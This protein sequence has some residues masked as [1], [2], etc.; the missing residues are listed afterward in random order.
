VDINNNG[1]SNGLTAPNPAAQSAVVRRTWQASALEPSAVQYAEAHGT[2]TPLGDPI[3]AQ[4]LGAVF[5]PERAG[6]DRLRIGSLKSNIG[7]AEG[8]AGIAGLI[9]VA[10]ALDHG[11]IPRSLHADEPNPL[12]FCALFVVFSAFLTIAFPEARGCGAADSLA[13]AVSSTTAVP[14]RIPNGRAGPGSPVR[15]KT[16]RAS[17][18]PRGAWYLR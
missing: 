15:G 14:A 17:A 12:I 4:A 16:V 13:R 7:H 2:G 5:A 11:A 1:R 18:R 6:D 9:K 10:L 8:A 3:E